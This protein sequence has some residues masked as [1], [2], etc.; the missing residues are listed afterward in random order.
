MKQFFLVPT[1]M[2]LFIFTTS[3]SA[4]TGLKKANK[5][6]DLQAYNLAVPKY[7]KVLSKK[8]HSTEALVKLGA[9]YFHQNFFV[10]A[11]KYFKKAI[12]NDDFHNFKSFLLPYGKTLMALEKYNLA[13][14]V[15]TQYAKV[16]PFVGNHFVESCGAAA[17]IDRKISDYVVK[18]EYNNSS[19]SD[20]GPALYLNDK[21]VF[22]SAKNGDGNGWDN[23]ISNKLYVSKRDKNRY[24]TPPKLVRSAMAG[25]QNEGPVSYSK[26]GK[27]VAYTK[28]NF[29]NGIRHVSTSGLNLSIFIAEV[30]PNGDWK[31]EK[32][33]MF[34]GSGY[35]SGFPCFADNGN[36]LYF[37][38]DRPDGLGGF[39]L[40]VSTRNGSSWSLPQ[41]LGSSVNTPGNE[42]TPFF[43]S[44][45]L[46]FASD[47]HFGLGGLDIFKA[48][49]S[50]RTYTNVV[51]LGKGI[52]SSF[53]DYGFI[54]D[55]SNGI[56]YLTSNRKGGKGKEDI[57]RVTRS[58]STA[59]SSPTVSTT[60]TNNT[61]GEPMSQP[62]TSNN[63]YPATASTSNAAMVGTP[64]FPSSTTTTAPVSY[65]DPIDEHKLTILVIDRE[66][67]LPIPNAKVNL[68]NC[69][70]F[71]D[72]RTDANGKFGTS[73]L[74]KLPC[75][76]V[77]EPAG[78]NSINIVIQRLG[79]EPEEYRIE[80]S[81]ASGEVVGTSIPSTTTPAPATT[82]P[83]TATPPTTTQ[84][85]GSTVAPVNHI[86]RSTR[87]Y[88][89]NVLN[90][91]DN[92]AVEGVTVIATNENNQQILETMTDQF[93]DFWLSLD[94]NSSYII[95]ISKDGFNS[96]DQVVKT[97]K[98]DKDEGIGTMMFRPSGVAASTIPTSAPKP[99]VTN[100]TRVA[101]T[102]APSVD[103]KKYTPAPMPE[104]KK[105]GRFSIQLAAKKGKSKM[106]TAPYTKLTD[107]GE[108][109]QTYEKGYTKLRLGFFS[110][111]SA[112]SMAKK[113][114]AKK[115]FPEAYIVNE[116]NKPANYSSSTAST[117]S[118]R[119]DTTTKY[120]VRLASL[121]KPQNFDRKSVERHGT[122]E[123]YKKGKF[124][125][126]LLSGYSSKDNARAAVKK[127]VKAGFKD[128]QLV[129][130]NNGNL[131]PIK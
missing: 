58:G 70:D 125:V 45:E 3:V 39:D 74:N 37:A 100:T 67:Q 32:P 41:N 31:N 1:L 15:F 122:I 11:E 78:Y 49:K 16:D 27:W 103:K 60:T 107:I 36:T 5:E 35:S 79:E 112:A 88:Q 90:V 84:L 64:S 51:N 116:T 65:I 96:S 128:A 24:L 123:T 19:D 23:N 26:D 12:G 56:G 21:I 59:T 9:C 69:D 120:K 50:G 30:L 52:N 99:K 33:F 102:P 20:F 95:R 130:D 73:K 62:T 119:I 97:A 18:N 40:F 85:E 92:N 22:T 113:S 117:N 38:S 7:L 86:E 76:F 106:S 54:Y 68:G 34:N 127:A 66:T 6:Y 10:D 17:A 98:I 115:G 114:A 77:I 46:H 55:H 2:W 104:I 43:N 4:Q 110:S 93:G 89:G 8:P 48:S 44:G 108:L 25:A 87:S 75:E 94:E 101:T 61:Y 81:K 121:T 57:Y 126:F 72:Y 80:L 14:N 13:S 124:T 83:M 29:T 109:Y 131:T 28:N 71:N 118:K 105:E 47:W 129:I 111:K 42:L 53:D 63:T 82:T 91:V